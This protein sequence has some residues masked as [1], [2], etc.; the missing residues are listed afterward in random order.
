MRSGFVK[1]AFDIDIDLVH[2]KAGNSNYWKDVENF[3]E[4]VADKL[5]IDLSENQL[6]WLTKI[7]KGLANDAG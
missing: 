1:D 2:E 7:E 6:R 3:F 4:K 5:C